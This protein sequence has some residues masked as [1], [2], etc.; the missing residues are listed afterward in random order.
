ME[1]KKRKNGESS[2]DMHQIY[3]DATLSGRTNVSQDILLATNAHINYDLAIA[4]VVRK[5]E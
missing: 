5:K 4:T 3:F 1:E 2:M